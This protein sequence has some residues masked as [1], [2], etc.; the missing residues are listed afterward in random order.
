VV[1]PNPVWGPVATVR[2]R[3]DLCRP[4]SRLTLKVVTT[5]NRVVLEKDFGAS[6]AGASDLGFETRDRREKAFS[7]GLYHLRLHADGETAWTS[8]LVLH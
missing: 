3:V 5:A 8:L 6:P 7:N 2:V 4:V 1:Y